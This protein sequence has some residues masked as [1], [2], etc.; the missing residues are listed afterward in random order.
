[1]ADPPKQNDKP[2]F[3][4]E[5]FEEAL[6]GA[7]AFEEALDAAEVFHELDADEGKPT[8]EEA[9]DDEVFSDDFEPPALPGPESGQARTVLAQGA[10]ES[11]ASA[12]APAGARASIG[13]LFKP[14]VKHSPLSKIRIEDNSIGALFRRFIQQA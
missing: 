7:E 4:D 9:L 11:R 14:V 3:E 10:L 5:A 12:P 13:Q 2:A 1:M 6:E 8:A